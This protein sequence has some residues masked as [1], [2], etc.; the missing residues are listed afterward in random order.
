MPNSVD[1]SQGPPLKT[2]QRL[3]FVASRIFAEEGCQE[4]AIA[5][6]DNGPYFQAFIA[7]LRFKYYRLAGYRG[8]VR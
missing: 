2:R 3:L 6:W 1:N 7:G 5:D 8:L 4:T